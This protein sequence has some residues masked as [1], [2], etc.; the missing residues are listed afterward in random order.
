MNALAHSNVSHALNNF[1]PIFRDKGDTPL[2]LV[3]AKVGVCRTHTGGDLELILVRSG[4]NRHKYGLVWSPR[5]KGRTF[6][7]S[8]DMERCIPASTLYQSAIKQGCL[9]R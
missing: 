5:G 6:T 8:F 9:D 4:K 7:Y 3:G 2:Y 1:F